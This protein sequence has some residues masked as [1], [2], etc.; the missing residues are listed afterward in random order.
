[1]FS[2]NCFHQ[3][4]LFVFCGFLIFLFVFK[5]IFIGLYL[6]YN[7][8]SFCSTQNESAIHIHVRVCV[9]VCVRSKLLQLRPTV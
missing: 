1:M 3:I 8:V 2:I 7:V 4:P 9:Y 5:L 6:L